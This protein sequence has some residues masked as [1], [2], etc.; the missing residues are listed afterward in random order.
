M[1]KKIAYFL[2]L[3]ADAETEVVVVAEEDGGRGFWRIH[4]VISCWG[5]GGGRGRGRK[6]RAVEDGIGLVV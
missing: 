4:P 2:D 1:N 6:E 5:S 3:A